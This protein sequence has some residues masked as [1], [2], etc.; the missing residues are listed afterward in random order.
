ML[1]KRSIDDSHRWRIRQCVPG[2]EEL[3]RDAYGGRK[4]RGVSGRTDAQGRVE[5]YVPAGQLELK[6]VQG[7][8]NVGSARISVREGERASADV[9]LQRVR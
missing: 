1:G 7:D 9:V 5:L 2:I 3:S 8:A 4:V 6:A